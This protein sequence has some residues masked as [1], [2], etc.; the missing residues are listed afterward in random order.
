[1]GMTLT[2]KI[3][4][5][6]SGNTSAKAGEILWVKVDKA[7]MD[8][9][10]GP[11]VEIAEKMKELNAE[12]W[13]SD[14]VVVISDHYTPPANAIQAEIVKFTREWAVEYNIDNYFEYVGPCHQI[15][16]ENGFALPGQV[17]VGTDSHTCMYGA[18]G[19][20]S[21]G[22]GSTEMLG[23]LVTGEIW[24]KVPETIKVEWEGK[25]GKGV[26]AKDIILKTIGVIGHAGATYKAVEYVGDTISDLNMD[27]RMVITNMA[28][29]KGAKN[30]IIHADDK[31]IKYLDDRGFKGNYDVF[32]SD[33]DAEFCEI[34]KFS[35][36]ELEPVVACPH[37]VDNIKN[38]SELE[39]VKID[40]AYIGSCTG[41]RY[42]D[43]MMAA[44]VLKGHK[45]AKGVRLLISPASKEVWDMCAKEGILQTLSEAGAVVL[46]PSC[47]ACLGI[48][49][50]ALAPK[51]VCISSTNR[52]FLGRMGSKESFVYLASP[53]SVAAA[54]IEGKIV[55]PRK[56]L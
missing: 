13:D 30:G 36:D 7:M 49:S 17:V 23:V 40:Q 26:M 37:E 3:L 46:A 53:V 35:A 1:M 42:Y 19:A 2:E 47:G 22:I 27:E 25:L 11:R 55:D 18:L 54:A 41:G 45:V 56:Y 9:I 4:A 5:K 43:L 8:D 51:E 32:S 28:V 12:V 31:T 29:E 52:N 39:E 21:T 10:L 48:H 50:G 16:V 24:L 33:E 6:A 44:K 20:F 38:I 15:M 34:F 14:K